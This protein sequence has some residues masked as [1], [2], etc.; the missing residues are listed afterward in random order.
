[1]RRSLLLLRHAKAKRPTPDLEDFD[2]T[3][4]GRGRDAARLVGKLL[5]TERLVPDLVLCS[6]AR[7]ARETWELVENALGKKVPAQY[8]RTLYLANPTAILRIVRHQA[9]AVRRMMVVGHNPGLERLALVLAGEAADDDIARLHA[10]FP[11]AALAAISFEARRWRD[12]DRGTGRLDCY[13][14]PRNVAEP[15]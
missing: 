3:L 1:M 12:I 2:R 15:A 11:T 13:L 5:R 9:D 10:K 7:R 14:V 8:D 6:S 4:N